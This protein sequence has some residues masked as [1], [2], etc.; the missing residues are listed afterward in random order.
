MTHWRLRT[1]VSDGAE[2]RTGLAATRELLQDFDDGSRADLFE[3]RLGS[4]RVIRE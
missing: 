3:R 2:H 4:A 1:P